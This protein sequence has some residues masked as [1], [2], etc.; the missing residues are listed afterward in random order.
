[1][2]S[3]VYGSALYP[4]V[5]NYP[6][7]IHQLTDIGLHVPRAAEQHVYVMLVSAMSHIYLNDISRITNC[8]ALNISVS[9]QEIFYRK[10][11]FQIHVLRK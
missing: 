2:A 6:R 11:D 4:Y 10:T 1:M 5:L 8:I 7:Q 3:N 9:I